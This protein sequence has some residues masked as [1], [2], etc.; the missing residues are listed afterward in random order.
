MTASVASPSMSPPDPGVAAAKNAAAAPDSD[1]GF[2]AMLSQLAGTP[3]ATA[4]ASANAPA[5]E[6]HGSAQSDAAATAAAAANPMPWMAQL[7]AAKILPPVQ[8]AADEP[9][10]PPTGN[11][12]QQNQAQGTATQSPA[13][14]PSVP[15]AAPLPALPDSATDEAG[16]ALTA[17]ASDAVPETADAQANATGASAAVEQPATPDRPKEQKSPHAVADSDQ[18]LP[19]DAAALT[20]L[21]PPVAAQLLGVPAPPAAQ[22]APTPQSPP[23]VTAT[24]I[25]K[26]EETL[27][28]SSLQ[29]AAQAAL[30][31]MD[32]SVTPKNASASE[33]K[34]SAEA[35]SSGP[36]D[37]RAAASADSTAAPA[38]TN[39]APERNVDNTPA[40]APV[41]AAGN[42]PSTA[43]GNA[44]GTAPAN[45]PAP[46]GH[47]TKDEPAG[48]AANLSEP[49]PAINPLANHA[50]FEIP[51][52]AAAN[53][54]PAAADAPVKLSFTAPNA[55]NVPSFD[56]LALKIAAR[57]SDGDNNFSIRLDPLDLGRIE[58]NLNVRSDGHARAELSADKPQTL[59][60]LQK[61]APALER[62]LKD[63]GL[64]LAG[65]LAFSLKGDGRSQTWR[66]PQS[67]SRGRA[68][69]IAAVDA[70]NA[71]ADVAVSTALAAHAYGL[72]KAR[73]D[74]RI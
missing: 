14:Q 21:S 69:Q 63:A 66:D 48:A 71:N 1:T 56:A 67:G 49:A 36:R 3:D 42:A 60:L 53:A 9:D 45:A 13:S 18:N 41:N 65:G 55:A 17:A 4:P 8:D 40:N 47:T 37:A 6:D 26:P 23:D 46:T 22:S 52:A 10:A 62:A 58:V 73:L 43:P 57:S 44:P 61:D 64:N 31:P 51:A 59:E 19:Q 34:P 70:A 38:N 35:R 15:V 33:T 24:P 74:I 30:A 20:D 16:T 28:A 27:A 68:L 32:K 39:D 7:E 54:P 11:P 2:G 50:A 12:P 72:P 29:A 5:A 25:P